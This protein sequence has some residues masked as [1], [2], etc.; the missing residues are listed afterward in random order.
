[1]VETMHSLGAKMNFTPTLYQLARSNKDFNMV[2]TL[3]N[4]NYHEFREE[5]SLIEQHSSKY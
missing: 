4:L 3:A 5:L 1:M 2:R